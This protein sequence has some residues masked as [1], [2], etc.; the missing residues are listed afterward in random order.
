MGKFKRP[1]RPAIISLS[2]ITLVLAA[3]VY[4]FVALN[5]DAT[6]ANAGP[7]PSPSLPAAT[8]APAVNTQDFASTPPASTCSHTVSLQKVTGAW[9]AGYNDDKQAT[10]P[11]P[12]DAGQFGLLD[13]DWLQV[14]TPETFVPGDSFEDSLSTVLSDAAQANPCSLRFVTINDLN[15]PKRVM[16]EIL[17]EPS[18]MNEHVAAVA[19]EMADLPD[20]TGLTM[21]YEFSLPTDPSDLAM[22]AQVGGWHNLTFDQEV[23]QAT[24]DY[25][26]LVQML[27]AAMHHQ[28]RLFRVAALV[29]NNDIVDSEQ[30]NVAPYLFDY[31]QLARYADQLV[32]EAIDFHYS[33][34]SPGP[35]APISDV[36]QV[37]NYVRSY[38][39]PLSKLDIEVPDYSYDW[40]VTASGANETSNGQVDPA[41]QL[42]PTGLATEMNTGTWRKVATQDGETEYTYTKTTSSGNNALHIVWDSATGIAYEK[43]QLA[44]QLPGA[45]I[46]IWQIGNNDP[47]GSALAAQV[48]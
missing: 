46:T 45:S 5:R 48:K 33:T 10:S 7:P 3:T 36:M 2:V 6:P 1:N 38:G 17:T 12:A 42:T 14:S 41:Q 35:I 4:I 13:F 43:A 31:G 15:T 34:G 40:P 27:A 32:L 23:N 11:I 47:V 21:D 28:H 44:K 25:T 24:L 29:R 9:I 16:A 22:Y 39:M 26:R 18:V 20:A 30:D 37:A 19:Q 8:T